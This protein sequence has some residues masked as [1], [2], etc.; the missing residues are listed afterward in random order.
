VQ[1]IGLPG[2]Q[3]IQDPLDYSSRVHHSNL[4]TLDHL[5]ADDIRQGA[6]VL[7]GM[8]PQAANSDKTL[9]REP[10]PT[11]ERRTNPFKYRDPREH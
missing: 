1:S 10:L 11:E 5:K 4:D 9:P 6:T 7:A 2:F 8:L 3:F